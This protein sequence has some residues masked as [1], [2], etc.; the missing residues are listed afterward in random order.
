MAMAYPAVLS[1][2]QVE[3]GLSSTAAGSISSAYQIGTAV[4]LVFVSAL[5]DYLDPRL[6][7]RVSAGLTAAV[8]ESPHSSWTTESTAGYAMAMVEPVA[9][10]AQ[11]PMSQTA[12]L[13]ARARGVVFV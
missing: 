8:E 2:V 9:R 5:A 1:V 13:R 3:W 10:A 11:R 6:L 4:A 7:F 12:L